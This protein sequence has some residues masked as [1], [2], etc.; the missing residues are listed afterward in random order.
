MTSFFREMMLDITGLCAAKCKA[1]NA[2]TAQ[3]Y[4]KKLITD[5]F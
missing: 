5:Y 1:A 3:N 2:N 4:K